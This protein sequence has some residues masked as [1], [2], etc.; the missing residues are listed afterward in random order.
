MLGPIP[1][2]SSIALRLVRYPAWCHFGGFT[3]L[4]LFNGLGLWMPGYF[5]LNVNIENIVPNIFFSAAFDCWRE[6]RDSCRFLSSSQSVDGKKLKK[7]SK[8]TKET[9]ST[10]IDFGLALEVM[11]WNWLTERYGHRFSNWR[12]NQ[13]GMFVARPTI[14][15]NS[16]PNL[17]IIYDGIVLWFLS[18]FTT[19][20]ARYNPVV[21]TETAGLG[22]FPI[23]GLFKRNS[24]CSSSGN[25]KTPP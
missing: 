24:Y 11:S 10:S 3:H 16:A 5:N 22:E 8:I 2:L 9:P 17:G 20:W 4:P 12:K 19:N 13:V 1:S 15:I 14:T 23:Y 21:K 6:S 25:G 18:L 7:Y